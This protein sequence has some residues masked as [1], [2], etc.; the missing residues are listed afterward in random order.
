MPP[1]PDPY[2][3]RFYE[4]CDHF[5]SQGFRVRTVGDIYTFHRPGT[6][7][8]L[9]LRR[10]GIYATAQQITKVNVFLTSLNLPTL[11]AVRPIITKP[12]RI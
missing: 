6:P 11:R 9:S 10:Q 8:T 3:M 4:V 12:P 7:Q 2:R 5:R 1:R